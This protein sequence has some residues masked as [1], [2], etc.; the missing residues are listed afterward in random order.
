M[1]RENKPIFDLSEVVTS[2]NTPVFYQYLTSPRSFCPFLLS[3]PVCSKKMCT[4][5]KS[6]Y[7]KYVSGYQKYMSGYQK[8]MSGYQKYVSEVCRNSKSGLESGNLFQGGI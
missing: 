7:Q 3:L 4:L 1:G 5:S 6:G 2:H 8:N